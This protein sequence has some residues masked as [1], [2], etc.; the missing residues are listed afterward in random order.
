MGLIDDDL[1]AVGAGG[2]EDGAAGGGE[3][4]D[5][6]LDGRVLGGAVGGYFVGLLRV[7]CGEAEG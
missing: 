5:G 6:G 2:D 3:A 4:V 7:R 1:L